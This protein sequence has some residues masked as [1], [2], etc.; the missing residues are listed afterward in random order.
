MARPIARPEAFH[1]VCHEC[2]G[3]LRVEV[4]ADDL[5][6]ARKSVGR[7]RKARV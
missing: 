5:S 3:V 1:V 7:S 4:T 6:I 2:E